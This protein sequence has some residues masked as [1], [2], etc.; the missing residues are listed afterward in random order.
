MKTL[1]V[2]VNTKGVN[3][4]AGFFDVF[5]VAVTSLSPEALTKRPQHL[6]IVVTPKVGETAAEWAAR[7]K[8]DDRY[9]PL[10]KDYLELGRVHLAFSDDG[11]PPFSH[12]D[13]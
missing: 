12:L 1:I 2:S 6:S 7:V 10:V 4:V 3:F 8:A 13:V 11:K 9:G 5:P